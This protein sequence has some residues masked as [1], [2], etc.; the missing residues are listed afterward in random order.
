M[1]QTMMKQLGFAIMALGFLAA[2]FFVVQYPDHVNWVGWGA[3]TGVTALGA[4]SIRFSQRATAEQGDKAAGNIV[5]LEGSLTALVATIRKLNQEKSEQNVFDYCKRIDNECM[6][7]INDFVEAREAIIHRFGL[8]AYAQVMDNFALAERSLNRAWCASADGYID[9]LHICI[10]RAE[11]YMVKAQ[12]AL[13][14]AVQA[15]PEG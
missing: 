3:C 1:S 7:D 11:V 9:E 2:A 12:G 8:A 6:D 15:R 5:T 4:L 14:Q 13:V 10:E